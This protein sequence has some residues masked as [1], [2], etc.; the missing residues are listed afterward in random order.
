VG[1]FLPQRNDLHSFV[2]WAQFRQPAK[3]ELR[4]FRNRKGKNLA[5]ELRL[6]LP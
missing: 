5:K 4:Y 2:P 1:G 3:Q 6:G